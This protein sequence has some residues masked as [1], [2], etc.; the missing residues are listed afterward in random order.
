[1][2]AASVSDPPDGGSAEQHE[3]SCV[4]ERDRALLDRFRGGERDALEVVYR[5]HA[6]EV[7][8]MLRS[9]FAS[10]NGP[11]VLGISEASALRDAV[12][13]V[14]VRAF[15]ESARLA[16]DGLRPYRPYLLRIARNVRI[17][18]L[19]RSG[20]EVLMADPASDGATEPPVEQP[21][22]AADRLHWEQ[23]HAATRAHVA[24]LDAERQRYVELRFVQ[25]LSQQQVAERMSLTRR[26]ARTLESDVLD[27]LRRALQRQGFR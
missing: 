22:D 23:Q 7:W 3:G 1:M 10:G 2:R 20:R 25:E 17:D 24:T 18:Q 4:F 8:S 6:G 16:Y 15:A 26:R 13:D 14:F 19:R 21:A 9:G 12:Q 11:R 27:G 5:Q